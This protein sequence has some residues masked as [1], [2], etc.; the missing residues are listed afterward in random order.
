[1]SEFQYYE[2]Q[3]IDH[4]L[5]AQ[6]RSEVE[7]LSS[8]IDV[9]TTRA[10]VDYSWGDF[11]HDPKQ[12]L[13]RYFDAFLYWTNWGSKQLIF[14]FPADLLDQ[15][16]IEPYCVDRYIILERV[17]DVYVLVLNLGEEASWDWIEPEGQLGMLSPLRNDICRAITER[18]ILSGSRHL[19]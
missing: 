8:H 3:T 7:W 14:R 11:K 16:R 2:W 4:P 5:T 6:E 15:K 1:M 12:V 19:R 13:A 17:D 9:S 10:Q 18:C